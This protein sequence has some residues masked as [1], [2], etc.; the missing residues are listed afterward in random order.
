MIKLYRWDCPNQSALDNKVYNNKLN[1]A[2]LINSTSW[3]CMYCESNIAHITY[4]DIEHIK[5]KSIYSDLTYKWDN[6][7]IACEVCNR[8]YKWVQDNN[9]I[10]P[11]NEDPQNH[12]I[13]LSNILHWKQWSEKWD[14]TISWIWLNRVELLERRK[15]KLDMIEKSIQAC[16]RTTDNE[17][18][19]NALSE[20]K[21]ESDS[22]KEF[23]LLIKTLFK[24]HEL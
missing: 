18:K 21:K 8:T 17:L 3:K 14:I 13:F 2:Q 16:F 10:N 19:N 9:F 7:W 22:S 1:K 20:L 5:A 4:W 12:L 24:L 6:L 23:S 11:Y 15:A